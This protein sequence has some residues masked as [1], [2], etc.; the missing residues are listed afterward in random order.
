[1]AR[2]RTRK[3]TCKICFKETSVPTAAPAFG[4]HLVCESCQ[5]PLVAV[6]REEGGFRSVPAEVLRRATGFTGRCLIHPFCPWCN[7]ITYGV[8]APAEG[9]SDPWFARKQPGESE[10]FSLETRCAHCGQEFRIEWDETPLQADCA[11]CRRKM[12]PTDRSEADGRFCTQCGPK[13]SQV[14]MRSIRP[15]L[16]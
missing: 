16:S 6:S 12:G 5:S 3:V 1:M 13:L 8:V 9:R 2:A 4:T 10:G 11:L 14:R 7:E 15:L